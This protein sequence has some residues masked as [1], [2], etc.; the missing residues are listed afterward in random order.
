MTL[1]YSP[2][3]RSSRPCSRAAVVTA[4]E[5]SPRGLRELEREHRAEPAH[6]ADRLVPGGELVEPRPQQRRDLLGALAE[7][8]LGELVEHRARRRAR[9]R[10]AAEGAAEP[11]R[12]RRVHQL[13]LAG[14]GRERQAAAERL[15][16]DDQVGLDAR[17]LDRPDGAGAPAAGLHLVGDV[18][19]PVPLA[20]LLQRADELGR[21]RDEPAL[22]LH[23][24]EHE[25]G[26]RV[27]R[28]VLLEQQLE[29]G[30]RVLDRDAAVRIGRRR[31]VDL[32]RER[33]EAL[34]VDELRGHRHRQV[35]A[36]VEGAV[37]DDDARPA[38]R[39]ARD[40]DRVLDRLGARVD[41]QRLRLALARP[42][43]VQPARDLDVRLVHPDHEALVQ[44]VVDLL[45]HGADDGLR[46]VPEVLAGDPAGEVEHLVAVGVPERRALG[47]GDDEVGGRDP[48]RHEALAR[49]AN[50]GGTLHLLGRHHAKP[51]PGNTL[52]PDRVKGGHDGTADRRHRTGLRGTDHR[53]PD[54]LPRLDRRLVGGALLAPEGLHARLH[55]R[56]RLHGEDQA[57]V[58]RAQRQ[59]DR[60]LGGSRRQP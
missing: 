29:A 44:V 42:E 20:E 28:D 5:T 10:V 54:Q 31:A 13:R 35:G 15:A 7:A 60:P 47:A 38:G 32:R 51:T 2:Q 52:L 8:R 16:G 18:D 39:G 53:R 45:V 49:L 9:D 46:V 48:A 21:H 55:D 27:G 4:F 24:L 17:V 36:A 37:E 22:A 26:D 12:V 3:E 23:R 57:G 19:D 41:E 1:P 33:P 34:L 59:G 25:A 30:E 40:L 56:A 14:H 11:A 50:G 58:R 43:R 6:L